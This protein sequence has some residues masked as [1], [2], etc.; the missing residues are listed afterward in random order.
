[1][2]EPP[3]AAPTCDRPAPAFS[4]LGEPRGARGRSPPCRAPWEP[5]EGAPRAAHGSH[6][7][8]APGGTGGAAISSPAAAARSQ[9]AGAAGTSSARPAPA[10]RR[11]C[12]ARLRLQPRRRGGGQRAERAGPG[13]TAACEELARRP[14]PSAR[15]PAGHPRAPPGARTLGGCGAFPNH[16]LRGSDGGPA[17]VCRDFSPSLRNPAATQPRAP[18]QE[19]G[20]GLPALCPSLASPPQLPDFVNLDK[21]LTSLHLRFLFCERR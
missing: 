4:Y 15:R 21:S 16:G 2:S 9:P 17:K 6:I 19:F 10:Q 12:G 5:S 11:D 8:A 20:W 3:T 14:T 18:A 1:M 7:P 13:Q